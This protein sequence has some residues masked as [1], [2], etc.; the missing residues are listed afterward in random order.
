MNQYIEEKIKI[1]LNKKGRRKIKTLKDLYI[2]GKGDNLKGPPC[3][4]GHI[5]TQR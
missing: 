2:E 5:E 1:F 3:L 4:V